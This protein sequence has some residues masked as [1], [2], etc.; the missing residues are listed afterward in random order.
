MTTPTIEQPPAL[1]HHHASGA[2]RPIRRPT[3]AELSGPS[4]PRSI[5]DADRQR[6]EASIAEILTA[7]GLDVD[8]PSTRDTPRRFLR[9][10]ED[11]TDGYD[12]DPKLVTVFPTECRGGADCEMAQVVEGPIPFA[13]LCEH[14]ALPF[15]GRAWVAYIA[16][17][18]IIGISKLTRLVRVLTRRFG[19]QERM[20]HQIADALEGML[21]AHGTAVCLEA[22]HMCTAIRGV[23]EPQAVTRTTAY[24]GAYTTD[25]TLRAEFRALGPTL[26]AER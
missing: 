7:L 26:G 4:V 16:H 21:A 19:V 18:R 2:I 1:G 22:Q 15:V 10:L 12:G 5:D 23:R 13:A 6:F 17:E 14:H 11:A 25:A 24:R 8:T 3:E 9:A 20:T